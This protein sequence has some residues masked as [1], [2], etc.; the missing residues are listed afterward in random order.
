MFARISSTA[1][2]RSRPATLALEYGCRQLDDW[3][4]ANCRMMQQRHDQFCS[5]FTA[6]Q[7]SF[8]LI[9]SGSFFA[10][11]KHPWPDLNSRQAARKLAEQA[12]LICLPGE[13]FGPGLK[14]YL[15]LAF[16]NIPQQQIPRAIERFLQVNQR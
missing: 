9:A 2:R 16:G 15:R 7:H 12:N 8:E 14:P 10:W 6:A 1:P 4:A 3:V 13:A 11:I 5:D